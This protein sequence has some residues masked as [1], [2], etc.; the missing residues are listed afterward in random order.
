[1]TEEWLARVAERV[2]A[3][4]VLVL[5]TYRPGYTP[6][7]PDR[8]FHTR[9]ALTTLSADDAVHVARDLLQA[10]ALPPDL[11]QL[12]IR[13]AEGNPFFVEEMVRS[14]DEIGALRRD[15]ERLIA[16]RPLDAALVPD[17]IQ[18]VILSRIDRLPDDAGRILRVAAAIGRDFSRRLLERVA[19][20]TALDDSL[21]APRALELIHER[22]A[23]P[24]V[25]YRFNHALTQEVTYASVPAEER[26]ELH[27][28]IAQ[29]LEGLHG[30]R[31]AEVAAVLAQ[32]CA[33]AEDWERALVYL[34]QAAE[35]AARAFATRDAL[36]LYGQALEAAARAPGA[37]PRWGVAIHQA[38][39]APPFP[40]RA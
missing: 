32:H 25:I 26:R 33:A 15:G 28:R 21:R 6:P 35:V 23:F 2:A 37:D 10:S 20:E 19:A 18:D 1:A 4:P 5:I 22:Q 14:L 27:R 34:V 8:T 16:T 3:Q 9:L 38:R 29:A 17:S 36:D 31:L 24:E 7:I 40:V 30:D 11:E 12:V 13:K 39:G